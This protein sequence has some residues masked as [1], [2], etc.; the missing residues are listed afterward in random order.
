MHIL[1]SLDGR[2]WKRFQKD[3]NGT[4]SS[5]FTP[6]QSFDLVQANIDQLPASEFINALRSC[7]QNN[8]T[9][10]G[11]L[12]RN[13]ITKNFSIRARHMTRGQVKRGCGDDDSI[14]PMNVDDS[15]FESIVSASLL[16]ADIPENIEVI[17]TPS[18]SYY[19]VEG[20]RK[21]RLHHFIPFLEPVD[22]DTYA[23]FLIACGWDERMAE[24]NRLICTMPPTFEENI[25]IADYEMKDHIS[26]REGIA[27]DVHKFL[28]G[29]R[30]KP[31]NSSHDVYAHIHATM[32]NANFYEAIK[33][34]YENL[35]TTFS[36]TDFPR[37]IK[38]CSLLLNSGKL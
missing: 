37:L 20:E 36:W 33:N 10:C 15:E 30:R 7:K 19:L 35:N 31:R 29:H 9:I 17:S 28:A 23:N 12:P 4:I 8:H 3:K 26:H 38:T 13:G 5:T 25:H 22:Q 32:N 27:L 14:M 24:N 18:S 1:K 2:P 6:G 21:F 34:H 11:N 16:R